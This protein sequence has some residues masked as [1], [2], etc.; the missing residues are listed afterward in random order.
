MNIHVKPGAVLVLTGAALILA[1]VS[2]VHAADD[3]TFRG[4]GGKP[5]IRQIVATFVP[6][7]LADPRIKE[8]FS[9]SDMK[10]V[11]MRLEEQFCVLSGGPCEYKGDPMKE[12]HGGLKITNAQFNA[13]A[14]DLQIAMERN[15]IPS[16]VQNKLVAT[17]APMQ[18]AIVTK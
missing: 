8:T 3:A 1:A 4:L 9:D 5:G 16:H 17:L 6:L 10:H 7:V 15:A 11:A 18:R 14:E 13:L 12:V 2:P